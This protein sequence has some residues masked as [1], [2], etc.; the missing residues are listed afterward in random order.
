M[1]SKR[2]AEDKRI[3]EEADKWF[4]KSHDPSASSVSVHFVKKCTIEAGQE[5]PPKEDAFFNISIKSDKLKKPA[6]TTLTRIEGS[7]VNLWDKLVHH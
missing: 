1:F 7:L 6:E 3:L 5:P 4:E 2:S